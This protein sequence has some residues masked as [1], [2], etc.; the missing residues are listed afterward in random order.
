MLGGFFLSK[1]KICAHREGERERERHHG[2]QLKVLSAVFKQ[3]TLSKALLETSEERQC[4]S[5]LLLLGPLV[6][7][8]EHKTATLHK[9]HENLL[10]QIE[11]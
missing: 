8:K 9:S 5:N 6:F 4:W 7:E 3:A 1:R 11:G 10:L 2:S